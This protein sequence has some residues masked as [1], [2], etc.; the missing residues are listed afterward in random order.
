MPLLRRSSESSESGES[1]ESSES[2]SELNCKL[3]AGFCEEQ[4]QLT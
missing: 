4:L 2:S 1:S 3:I